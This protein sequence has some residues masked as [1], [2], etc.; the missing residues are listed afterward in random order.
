[1]G[2]LRSGKGLLILG[3]LTSK[4]LLG[5]LR[6]LRGAF[7]SQFNAALDKNMIKLGEL[8]L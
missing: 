5:V 8:N 2:H 4:C 3:L 7:L 1:M 6:Y